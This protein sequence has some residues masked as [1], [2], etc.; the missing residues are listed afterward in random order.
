[1]PF[2]QMA[3]LLR[4]PFH[5]RTHLLEALRRAKIPAHFSR[6][7]TRPEPVAERSWHCSNARPK[8]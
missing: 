6:E 2:D 4:S 5:Y 3:I 1:M 7:A 8:A